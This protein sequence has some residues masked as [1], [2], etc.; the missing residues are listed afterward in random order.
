M[1][2]RTAL[3]PHSLADTS[4]P[5]GLSQP[6]VGTPLSE[7]PRLSRRPIRLFNN[8]PRRASTTYGRHTSTPIPSAHHAKEL[9]PFMR[10][11]DWFHPTS[12]SSGKRLQLPYPV[13][14]SKVSLIKSGPVEGLSPTSI[15]QTGDLHGLQYKAS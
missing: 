12:G 9:C 1:S 2:P 8:M 14:L 5:C 13:P 15:Q 7:F 11:V 3:G 4:H 6:K 10:C